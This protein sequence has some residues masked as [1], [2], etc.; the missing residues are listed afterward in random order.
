MDCVICCTVIVKPEDICA[1]RC[2]H[3]YHTD[4]IH[5]WLQE[6]QTCPECKRLVKRSSLTKLFTKFVEGNDLLKN[7][8]KLCVEMQLQDEKIWKLEEKQHKKIYEALKEDRSVKEQ[9][10]QLQT[11]LSH[12]REARENLKGLKVKLTKQ[13]KILRR[14]TAARI[15][16][17]LWGILFFILTI[18][19]IPSQKLSVFWHEILE[20]N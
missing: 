6:S 11:F 9:Q 20:M 14:L 10:S 7:I 19:F 15:R 5:K 17:I 16:S 8:E 4:C 1:T 2:G 12:S 13:N 18:I 3:C